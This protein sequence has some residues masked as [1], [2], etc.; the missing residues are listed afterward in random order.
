MGQDLT[1]WYHLHYYCPLPNQDQPLPELLQWSLKVSFYC[2]QNRSQGDIFQKTRTYYLSVQTQKRVPHL[3]Q[4]ESQS[5]NTTSPPSLHLVTSP[6][7]LAT[8]LSLTPGLHA[9][10]KHSRQYQHQS[11]FTPYSLFLEPSSLREQHTNTHSPFRFLLK[12][13]FL[14]EAFSPG[15]QFPASFLSTVFM[16]TRHTIYVH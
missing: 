3:T 7:P 14:S 6:G 1:T 13:S 8:S 12:C 2:A 4:H 16:N 9:F 15:I 5:A 11:L 10:L